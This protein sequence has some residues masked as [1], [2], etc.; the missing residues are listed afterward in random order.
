MNLTI[1]NDTCEDIVY[2]GNY[3]EKLYYNGDLVW[4]KTVHNY[5]EEY[6]TVEITRAS[7]GRQLSIKVYNDLINSQD[8]Q[9][10]QTFSYSTDGGNTWKTYNIHEL[11][12][13]ETMNYR[14]LDIP[15]L[16]TGSKVLFKG[17]GDRLK[18]L[19]I[20]CDANAKLYGNAMS[21]LYGD[22]FIGQ[23]TLRANYALASVFKGYITDASNLILPATTLTPNCYDS[24]FSGSYIKN[25]S[26]SLPA[27][28]LAASCYRLMFY[29]CTNLLTAPLMLPA[30]TLPRYC[31]KQMFYGCKALVDPPTIMATTVYDSC[32]EEMF[33]GCKAL[34][35]V[36]VP[37]AKSLNGEAC[38]KS[39]FYGCTSL[40]EAVLPAE[41]LYEQ[42][43]WWMFRGCTSLKKITCYATQIKRIPS[44]NGYLNIENCVYEWVRDV[45]SVGDFYKPA[46]M[47]QW[48][49]GKSGIPDGW[50]V[51]DITN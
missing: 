48:T 41:T 45:G 36:S 13:L 15:G 30:L 29:G 3:L 32:C 26:F 34:A 28:T 23:T 40:V 12:T 43:Y 14:Q 27:T 8:P 51:H 25:A 18:G 7:T 6:L 5:E 46:N 44:G 49:T 19:V 1:T 33:Y 10:I 42:S 39:M 4:E 20:L 38:Y 17:E 9:D 22:N 11:Y 37:Q 24:M 35:I 21:L 2:N 50:T 31:Y 47:T 16:S